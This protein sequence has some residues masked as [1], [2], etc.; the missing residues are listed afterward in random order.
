MKVAQ[1][2]Y[3]SEVA[4]GEMVLLQ[5]LRALRQAGHD[6]LVFCPEEGELTER[7]SQEGTCYEIVPMRKTY[8]VRAVLA[9]R[10]AFRRNRI[11]LVHSHGLLVN[12]L[13]RFAAWGAGIPNVGT[14][15]LTRELRRYPWSP[16]LALALKFRYYYRT[17]DNWSQRLSFA[18]IAV[19]QAVRDDLLEQGYPP[20]RVLVIPNGIDSQ[21]FDSS[22]CSERLL[23]RRQL[24][25]NEGD[26][27]VGVVARLSPQKDLQTFIEAFAAAR[28]SCKNLRAFVAGTGPQEDLLRKLAVTHELEAD[29][30]FL[31]F[32]RDVPQLL[33][34]SDVFCLTSRWEGLPLSVLEAMASGR[35]VVATAVPGTAE[36]V[37]DGVTGMLL[38]IG[39]SAAVADALVRV[40]E[41]EDM[42]TRMGEAGRERAVATFGVERVAAQHLELYERIASLS[43]GGEAA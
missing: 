20:S 14:V 34:A 11:D 12:V 15:H 42:R 7:L 21:A 26:V 17:L 18:T 13:T 40:A 4:G 19:S 25:V 32:R 3:R 22:N 23:L 39:D 9:L 35:P 16:S 29:L 38:P 24:G 10:R 28:R 27:L 1:V 36:A 37:V 6:T 5:L 31:G 33:R 8:D 43:P 41:S 2:A 30:Q